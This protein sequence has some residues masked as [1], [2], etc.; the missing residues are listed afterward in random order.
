MKA[1]TR[2]PRIGSNRSNYANNSSN[3]THRRRRTGGVY[4]VCFSL[5]SFS[6]CLKIKK[7]L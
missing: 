4:D 5:L 2:R 6:D 3:S 1:T 7:F